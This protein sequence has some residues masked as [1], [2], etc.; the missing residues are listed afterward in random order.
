MISSNSS[1]CATFAMFHVPAYSTC[2]SSVLRRPSQHRPQ[3]SPDVVEHEALSLDV[4]VYAI[5][6]KQ[7]APVR[8]SLEQER[9]EGRL[10]LVGD[11]DKAGMELL[12][13][14]RAV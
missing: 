4:G 3:S 9:Y 10:R 8:E 13:V 1:S 7:V 12:G 11:S 6:L 2:A 14:I 5:R